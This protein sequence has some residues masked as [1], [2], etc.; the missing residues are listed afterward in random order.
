M[1][2]PDRPMVAG[3]GELLWDCLPGGRRPGGAPANVA[4][5][6]S[7]LGYGGVVCSRVG[8]DA[9]GADLLGELEA[10][11]LGVDAIQIDERLPTGQVTV[12]T[13]DA[14]RPRYTIH[15]NVAWDA[16][17]FDDAL[18]AR[19]R[20]AAAVCVG[21]LAQRAEPSRETI[22]RCLDAA[23]A[24]LRVYDVNLRPGGDDP[25][26]VAATLGRVHVVKLN[27]EE[28]G[29]LAPD[30]GLA[31]SKPEPFARH[32]IREHGVELVCV[33]RAERGCLLVSADE[34]VDA[35]GKPVEVVDAVG[36][37]DAFTAAL[38]HA[39]LSRWTLERSARLANAVG[40]LVASRRGA[41]PVLRPEF[42]RLL[43]EIESG[44]DC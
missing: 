1:T 12:D 25:A 42:D 29:K 39:R 35:Q 21:T 38:I 32:L 14:A 30:F 11:G 31:G 19:M 44:P 15:E 7:Q 34:T 33:T 13:S 23:G 40:A 20:T 41:M 24:A 5:H 16:L 18:A 37:G 17:E 10:R 8:R 28:V 26:W 2:E 4:H 6:A 43:D 3:V 27:L 36:A 22:G 9:P